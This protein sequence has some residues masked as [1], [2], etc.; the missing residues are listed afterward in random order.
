MLDLGDLASCDSQKVAVSEWWSTARCHP[1]S[2]RQKWCLGCPA[3]CAGAALLWHHTPCP[4][5]DTGLLY[6]CTPSSAPTQMHL[7]SWGCDSSGPVKEGLGIA[8]RCPRGHTWWESETRPWLPHPS[9]GWPPPPACLLCPAYP[10]WTTSP[11]P[12]GH[13]DE[14][15]GTSAHKALL[16]PSF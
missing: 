8:G 4:G 16:S 6:G 13:V 10:C 1:G 9:P 5:G 3:G 12:G 2:G 15:D 11:V 7:F 14:A